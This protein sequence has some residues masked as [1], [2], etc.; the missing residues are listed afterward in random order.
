MYHTYA[1]TVQ[2]SG[3][4]NRFI[5]IYIPPKEVV[6]IMYIYVYKHVYNSIL[7]TQQ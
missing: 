4:V 7:Y 2:Y 1:L 5:Y 6:Y 3:T